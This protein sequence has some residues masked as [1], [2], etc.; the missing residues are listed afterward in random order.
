MTREPIPT[1]FDGCARACRQAITH[2]YAWG[3]CAYAPESARPEPRISIPR[4]FRDTDGKMSIGFD[5]YT[6][7]ELAARIERSLRTVDVRLGQ[8]SVAIL[9]RGG[10]V[11]LSG[12]EY[13][14]MA[15]AVAMDLVEEPQ[16]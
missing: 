13:A 11:G 8:N 2:T 15:L 6:A 9:Q 14:A 7:A 10:T 12:G 4:T 1:D 5:T 16:P 3:D